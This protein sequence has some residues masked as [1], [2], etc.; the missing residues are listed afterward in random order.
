MTFKKS[1]RKDTKIW[2]QIGF[3][4]ES[5]KN[6]GQQIKVCTLFCARIGVKYFQI[7]KGSRISA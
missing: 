5:V 3:S 1:V 6:R 7:Q 4:N 2:Q